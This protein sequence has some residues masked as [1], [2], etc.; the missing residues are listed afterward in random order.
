MVRKIVTARD[1]A[2]HR[3]NRVRIA[4]NVT[5]CQYFVDI[6]VAKVISDQKISPPR[7]STFRDARSPIIPAIVNA[8][9][10]LG[11]DVRE[12]PAT[13]ELLFSAV[14]SR[15]SAERHSDVLT[16]GTPVATTA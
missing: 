15:H 6:A 7:I 5:R 14:G 13:P 9:R 10:S 12:V 16:Y 2:E 3:A 11:I 1:P 8:I 4:R